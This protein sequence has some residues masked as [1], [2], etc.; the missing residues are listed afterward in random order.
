MDKADP[1]TRFVNYAQLAGHGRREL[2]ADALTIAAAGL[3]AAD[4]AA[5]LERALRLDGDRLVVA[6]QPIA[7]LDSRQPAGETAIGLAGRRLFL[8]GAGKATIGMAA[9]LD[10]L[11]GPRFTDAAVVVKRGQAAS[12]PS[13]CATS[14]CS[15][16]RIR[17]PT[18]RALR[19]GCACSPSPARRSPA[20]CSSAS[21]PAA[22]R[23]SRSPRQMV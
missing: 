2:R 5:A 6:G 16:P 10:R 3:R 14:R 21:S 7:G 12:W 9:V 1:Q 17:C 8:V 15:R 19:A 4:P 11:L 23:P 20:T 18:S 22:A 13:R